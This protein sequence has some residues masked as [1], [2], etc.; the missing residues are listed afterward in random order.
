MTKLTAFSYSRLNAY[1]ECPKKYHAISVAK[2][3]KEPPS[4]TTDYGTEVHQHFANFFKKGTPLPLHLQQYGK[5]LAK[6]KQYPGVFITEQKLAINADYEPT[7]WFDG[8]VYCRIISDLTILNGTNGAM[9]DWKTGKM[10]DDFLQLRLA[11]AVMFLLVPEL[12]RIMLAYFWTKTK[13][14][15]KE[16]L[17]RE[18][19]PGVW[20][21]LIPRIQRYHNAHVNHDFP[22]RQSWL[23]GYCPVNSCPYWEPRRK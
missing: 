9:F 4:E 19:M 6:I 3:H 23:C 7:G 8:D 11:G 14:I 1:E 12:Q 20:S 18:Q 22:P 21:E 15:T 16:V 17:T 2:S 5:Y 10:K 13:K